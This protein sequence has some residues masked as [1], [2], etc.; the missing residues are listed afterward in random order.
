MHPHQA[1]RQHKVEHRR[2]AH[3]TKGYA[4]GGA[5]HGDEAADLALIK[6]HV[7]KSALRADGGR[8][9]H[10][11]DRP[12]RASGGRIHKDRSGQDDLQPHEGA[13]D[14]NRK[15]RAKGGRAKHKGH[16][17]VNV[18]VAPHNG[19]A[20]SPGGAGLPPPAA[21]PPA[22]MLGAAPPP[23][24][25]MPPPGMAPPGV[26]GPPPGMPPP[27]LARPGMPPPGMPLRARG[28]AVKDG[29][30]YQEGVRARPVD[31]HPGKMD[32]AD[33]DRSKVI[34][35][36]KGGRVNIYAKGGPVKPDDDDLSGVIPRPEPP[37]TDIRRKRG[38]RANGLGTHHTAP[39]LKGAKMSGG[40]DP[41]K[42]P[43]HGGGNEAPHHMGKG[44]IGSEKG[45]MSPNYN[46]GGGGGTARLKKLKKA[47]AFERSV[48]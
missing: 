4:N 38:G 37:G 39:P 45:P 30:A 10:R 17:T 28:G 44:R 8:V 1:H 23:R 40:I 32:G 2:V 19:G 26:G 42:G 35:Y 25:P 36:K 47:A 41:P 20:P 27:G 7:K 33:L 18:M 46:A 9:K 13:P 12:R 48:P 11:A 24:P 29:P 3:I 5:V 6:S 34:T 15:S 14:D 16:T 43:K 31:H 22:P 21:P